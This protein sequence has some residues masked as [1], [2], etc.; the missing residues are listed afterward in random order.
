MKIGIR[1]VV[2][3]GA[4]LKMPRNSRIASVTES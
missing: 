2:R 4:A 3:T 1:R